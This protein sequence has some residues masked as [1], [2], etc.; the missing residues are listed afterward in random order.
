MARTK[1]LLLVVALLNWDGKT[2]RCDDDRRT[3]RTRPRRLQIGFAIAPGAPGRKRTG[4]ILSKIT[5]TSSKLS[6][7][8]L[9]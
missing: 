1:S 5:S 8:D 2:L 7:S 9:N 3:C 6:L 4:K